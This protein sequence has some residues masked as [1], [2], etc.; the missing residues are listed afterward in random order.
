MLYLLCMRYFG[1]IRKYYYVLSV[2][3]I[4]S[5]FNRLNSYL[6]ISLIPLQNKSNYIVGMLQFTF[7]FNLIIMVRVQTV[8]MIITIMTLI[9]SALIV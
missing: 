4:L 9:C 7:R 8:E 3:I 6:R 1:S 5:M 2:F